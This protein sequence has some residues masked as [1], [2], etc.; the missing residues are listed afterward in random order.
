MLGP[1]SLVRAAAA[2]FV[3][4]QPARME[5]DEVQRRGRRQFEGVAGFTIGPESAELHQR[6]SRELRR[7]RNSVESRH[8]RAS[9]VGRGAPTQALR[10][11]IKTA[12]RALADVASSNQLVL[13]LL[14]RER[15]VDYLI[16]SLPLITCAFAATGAAV[17]M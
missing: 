3:L 6:L 8:A 15:L 13:P 1:Q 10:E 7:V 16:Y 5:S 4:A 9:I 14:A 12:R 11:K 17:S 2:E